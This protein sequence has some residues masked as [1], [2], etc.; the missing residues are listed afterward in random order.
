MHA[1]GIDCG[2]LTRMCG[3]VLCNRCNGDL[4][5][6]EAF[7]CDLAPEPHKGKPMPPGMINALVRVPPSEKTCSL[8]DF[9]EYTHACRALFLN[10]SHG[11]AVTPMCTEY[12]C[13]HACANFPSGCACIH[14]SIH[15][16]TSF[17]HAC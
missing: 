17:V 3:V 1:V 16:R 14:K 8:N 9:R 11:C 4:S 6:I 2:A 5:K 10:T 12:T 7:F 15:G 13:V